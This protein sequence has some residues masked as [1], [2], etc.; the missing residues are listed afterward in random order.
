MKPNIFRLATKELSQDGFFTWLLQWADNSNS[1]FDL[2][3]NDTA[4]DF[5]RLL[6]GQTNDY[7]ITKVEAG[8]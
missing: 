4:K 5:I 6:I 8:R 1:Q 3:L 7:Q 2:Q